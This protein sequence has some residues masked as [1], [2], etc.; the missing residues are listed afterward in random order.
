MNKPKTLT[1][2]FIAFVFTLMALSCDREETRNNSRDEIFTGNYSKML[3]NRIDTMLIG[4]YNQVAN[5]DLDLDEDGSPDFRLTSEY[6]GSPGMGVYPRAQIVSLSSNSLIN[7]NLINDTT[8][9]HFR[10][11][12]S[13]GENW[14]PVMISRTH[15]Y[16]CE[17]TE[18]NDSI[19]LIEPDQFEISHFNTDESIFR[20]DHYQA[21]TLQLNYKSYYHAENPVYSHDT[22]FYNYRSYTQSCYYFP[23]DQIRYIGVKLKDGD[24]ESLGWIKLGLF[25]NYKLMIIET[26][27]LR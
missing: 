5:F 2:I 24:K 15:I 26:A 9:Y 12:T 23:T 14:T 4:G 11:D 17:R 7:G 1:G 27:L 18:P 22:I 21:D 10:A 25:D 16:S 13:Y 20:T 19:T 6:Y 8:F 3:V